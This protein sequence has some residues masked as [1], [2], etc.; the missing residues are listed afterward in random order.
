MPPLE[1]KSKDDGTQRMTTLAANDL[2]VFQ[3][4]KLPADLRNNIYPHLIEDS[5]HGHAPRLIHKSK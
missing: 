5:A 2:R 1:I 3:F 4:L